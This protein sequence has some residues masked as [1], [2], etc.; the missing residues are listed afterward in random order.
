MLPIAV[1]QPTDIVQIISLQPQVTRIDLDT[2]LVVVLIIIAIVAFRLRNTKVELASATFHL[3]VVWWA[4]SLVP[5]SGDPAP[6]TP[7]PLLNDHQ[8]L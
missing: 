6:G 2:S 7:L 8:D 4:M 1:C 5:P 3:F